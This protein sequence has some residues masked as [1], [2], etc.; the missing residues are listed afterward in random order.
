[1]LD[2]SQAQLCT[3]ALRL[4]GLLFAAGGNSVLTDFGYNY[5]DNMSSTAKLH[6]FNA[7]L[8][9]V[10]FLTFLGQWQAFIQVSVLNRW[11]MG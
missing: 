11:G 5:Y 8:V 4:V 3:L 9:Q 10:S 7:A 6:F 1:V 2:N